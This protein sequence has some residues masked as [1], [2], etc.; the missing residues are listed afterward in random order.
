MNHFVCFQ[1]VHYAMS[2]LVSWVHSK[3]E[4]RQVLFSGNHLMPWLQRLILEDPEPAVRREVC[5]ALYRLCLGTPQAAQ[6][7][8]GMMLVHLMD[9]L[10]VAESMRPP[11]IEVFTFSNNYYLYLSIITTNL[12]ILF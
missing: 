8:A 4:V 9:Y 2:L 10:S 5:T 12:M 1:V 11:K 6:T 3:E 7:F